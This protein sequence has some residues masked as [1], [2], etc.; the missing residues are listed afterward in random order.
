MDLIYSESLKKCCGSDQKLKKFKGSYKCIKDATRRLQ[1]FTEINFLETNYN[2][3][4]VDSDDNFFVFSRT[5]SKISRGEPVTDKYFPKCCPLNYHYNTIMHSC[6]EKENRNENLI[7]KKYVKVGLAHCRV[8]EDFE[9]ADLGKLLLTT[10][11][12]GTENSTTMNWNEKASFC[13][14]E[15]E[16]RT[17]IKR[18][19]KDDLEICETTKCLRKCCPDGQ[20]FINGSRCYD[21][22]THGIDLSRL[23]HLVQNYTGEYLIF[24]CS[25]VKFQTS[26][27]GVITE[28]IKNN[29]RKLFRRVYLPYDK[30]SKIIPL[31]A[32]CF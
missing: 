13:I 6:E 27:L 29:N 16:K 24:R 19:C 22:Y 31:G 11:D 8:I 28:V 23:K 17:Y 10:S 26:H 18:I 30:V 2:G 25:S 21:T 1:I 3:Q 15:T 20:S 12:T 5:S 9:A 32:Y 7:T 4:C 14:D